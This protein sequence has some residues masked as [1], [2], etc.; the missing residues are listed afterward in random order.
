[1]RRILTTRVLRLSAAC[2]ALALTLSASASTLIRAKLFVAPDGELKPDAIVLIDGD[3]IVSVSDA[4]A[5]ANDTHEYSGAVLCPGL[6]E[7]ASQAGAVDDLNDAA[8]P[9]Q[10]DADARDALNRRSAEYDGALRAGITTLVLT[11][12]NENPIGG[13]TAIVCFTPQSL[14]PVIHGDTAP[15]K[16]SL[17]PEALRA[18][19]EP[20]SRNGLIALL[21]RTLDAEK[22]DP[23]PETSLG[24]LLGGKRVGIVAAPEAADV[25]TCADLAKSYGL[26]LAPWHSSDAEEVAELGA[27]FP[28]VIVGPFDFSTPARHARSAAAFAKN[29]STVVIAGGLPFGATDRLRLGAAIA[30]RSGLSPALARRAITSAPADLLGLNESHGR[31]AP[32]AMADLVVFS[33]D[34][35]DLRSR[36]LAVYVGGQRVITD[37]SASSAPRLAQEDRK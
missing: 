2:A 37:P 12:S 6:I 31:L 30:A 33:G 24:K 18:V 32:G 22:A 21:R 7:I 4:A 5:K 17:S 28:G 15:L 35:L 20:S 23:K 16:L 9:I 10:V 13:S 8:N 3:R 26:R 19:Y 11:P 25:L 29:N 14:R 34:P 1:M 27:E 36:V